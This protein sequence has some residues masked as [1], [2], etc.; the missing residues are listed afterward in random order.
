MKKGSTVENVA[1][2]VHKDFAR[3]LK[4]AKIWGSGK[5]TGQMVK[6]DDPVN[7]GDV[8]ELHL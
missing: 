5:F 4:Y 3:K 7:E 1:L 2:S 8:I 6:R